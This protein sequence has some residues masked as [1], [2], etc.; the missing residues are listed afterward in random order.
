MTAKAIAGARVS[1]SDRPGGATNGPSLARLLDDELTRFDAWAI[2]TLGGGFT[3]ME[4]AAIKTYLYQKI[5]GRVD[6]LDTAPIDVME[7]SART[8]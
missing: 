8:G 1:H 5:V 2:K 3:R 6:N 7:L 4:K